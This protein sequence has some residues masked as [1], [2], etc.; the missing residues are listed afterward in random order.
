MSKN[1]FLMNIFG[2]D[3]SE[4]CHMSVE[5]Q[6]STWNVLVKCRFRT[7]RICDGAW[8]I[9]LIFYLKARPALRMD[10]ECSKKK[11]RAVENDCKMKR[12]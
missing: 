10:G 6:A 7:T 5:L 12:I 2:A 4:T 11:G 1:V 9:C 3:E 8:S